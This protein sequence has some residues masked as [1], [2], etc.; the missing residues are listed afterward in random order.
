VISAELKRVCFNT[1]T[2]HVGLILGKMMTVIHLSLKLETE[3]EVKH[4]ER[5]CLDVPCCCFWFCKYIHL[6]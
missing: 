6:L 1:I 4:G 2:G 3:R 5:K